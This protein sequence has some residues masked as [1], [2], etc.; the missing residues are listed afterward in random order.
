MGFK[1][2]FLLTGAFGWIFYVIYS[3]MKTTAPPLSPDG[4][5]SLIPPDMP[6]LIEYF[7]VS[8]TLK[9]HL[10]LNVTAYNSFDN[11]QVTDHQVELPLAAMKNE[12]VWLN[13][14]ASTGG[15]QRR[16]IISERKLKL[17]RTIPK[18]HQ[19]PHKRYLLTDPP[20]T[21]QEKNDKLKDSSTIVTAIPL[22]IEAGLVI[23]NRRM[24]SSKLIE[25]GLSMAVLDKEKKYNFGVTLNTLIAPRDEYVALDPKMRSD[26]KTSNQTLVLNIKYRGIGF[27]YWFFQKIIQNAFDS[28]ENMAVFGEYDIDSLKMLIGGSH[29]WII[30]LVHVTTSLHMVFQILA[31]SHDVSFWS[32][33]NNFDNYSANS[34]Q[35]NIICDLIIMLFLLDEGQSK[36]IILTTIIRISMDVWK[37]F[38]LIDMKI[39]W[40]IIPYITLKRKINHKKIDIDENEDIPEEV[41]SLDNFEYTCLT[42]LTKIMA[43]FVMSI[44]VY[45]LVWLK[46]KNWLSFLVQSAAACAY[47]MGFVSM[48][49][50]LFRNYRLKSADHLPWKVMTYQF[51]NTIIDDV[52]S[53][54]IRMPQMHRVSVFRDD[55]VFVGY[56]AQLFYYKKNKKIKN[57]KKKE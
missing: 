41:R 21:E 19:K 16:Q 1:T 34:L 56:L 54:I 9:E 36:L 29:P 53:M 3:M 44:W 43:P 14:R 5:E 45:Q 28:M 27:S 48:T 32:K 52:F 22:V 23:E 26:D 33:K 46:Q 11:Y 57:D 17:S 12:T 15:V 10:L 30:I 4:Y 6:V 35:L 51:L 55:V 40:N 24:D 7:L 42:K 8:K 18:S 39:E 47:T 25:G 13:V 49:P 2:G 38:K 37:L 50:Q 20:L 31:V